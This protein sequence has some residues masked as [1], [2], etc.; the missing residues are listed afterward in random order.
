MKLYML[1]KENKA[2]NQWSGCSL[3][4]LDKEK[5]IKPKIC[6]TNTTMVTTD[7]NETEY[8]HKIQKKTQWNKAFLKKNLSNIHKWLA[9]FIQKHR[10]E[11]KM[12]RGITRNPTDIPWVL[13]KYCQLLQSNKTNSWNTYHTQLG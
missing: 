3:R 11:V 10:K 7:F 1:H 12:I 2:E 8:D 6:R 5:Q 13:R 9:G 4:N